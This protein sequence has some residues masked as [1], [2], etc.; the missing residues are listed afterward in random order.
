MLLKS[1]DLRTGLAYF[2]HAL[3]PTVPMIRRYSLKA[4]AFFLLAG[5][6]FV[7]TGCSSPVDR[8]QQISDE[9]D[10]LA[11]LQIQLDQEEAEHL[12]R[13]YEYAHLFTDPLRTIRDLNFQ[14]PVK[15]KT[16]LLAESRMGNS[17]R[18]ER[19]CMEA[20]RKL[21]AQSIEFHSEYL[22]ALE[23]QNTPVI[24]RM[25][26]QLDQYG[27]RIHD[28]DRAVAECRQITADFNSV[29]GDVIHTVIDRFDSVATSID[30][31]SQQDPTAEN[32]ALATRF[33]TID[34][35]E[36]PK[37]LASVKRLRKAEHNAVVRIES[38]VDGYD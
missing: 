3:L 24:A 18:A 23:S 22:Q 10:R 30:D 37:V 32:N 4:F 12:T 25:S 9:R 7:I 38:M 5:C 8:W 29:A 27:Q 13:M 14:H 17:Q 35:H 11:E 21:Y 28:L 34:P 31:V 20:I 15:T 16:I 33:I 36:R 1:L 19:T 26:Q 2:I 6:L